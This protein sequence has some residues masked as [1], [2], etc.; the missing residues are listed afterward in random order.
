MIFSKT[1]IV[2]KTAD[3]ELFEKLLVIAGTRNL[4]LKE[5]LK[6][7]LSTVSLSI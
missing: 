2:L 1:E 7:E 4:D 3:R 6:Y 5:I